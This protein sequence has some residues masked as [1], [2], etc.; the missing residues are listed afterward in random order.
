MRIDWVL[1]FGVFL[2][3]SLW[4]FAY[5]TSFYPRAFGM[6]DL[7]EAA[8]SISN[9]V[10]DY[11]E[12]SVYD[13][14]VRFNSSSQA[15]D[16]V[17]YL[18]YTWNS[19]IKNSTRILLGSQDL[20]CM[21]SGSRVYW[22]SDLAQGYNYFTMRFNNY[23]TTLNCNSS[24]STANATRAFPWT[25]E[26]KTMVALGK[27]NQMRAMN[28]TGFKNEIGANRDFRVIIQYPGGAETWYGMNPPN[29]TNVYVKNMWSTIEDTGERIKLSVLVW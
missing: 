3:F 2:V 5:Y 27:I 17:L 22:Q 1:A 16:A 12:I 13:V 24:F 21:L 18:D 8:N 19:G 20:P 25:E 28:F 4:A 23:N 6:E 10:I 11:L 26:R 9:A 29:A 7:K 14:P 15:S